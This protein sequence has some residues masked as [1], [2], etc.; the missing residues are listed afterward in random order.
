MVEQKYYAPGVGLVYAVAIQGE[1][2]VLA[3]LDVTVSREVPEDSDDDSI[4]DADE[5]GDV[6]GIDDEEGG[7]EDDD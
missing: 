7:E 3:L 5:L 4:E 2:E 6:D 1:S